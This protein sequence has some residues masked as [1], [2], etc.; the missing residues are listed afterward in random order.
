MAAKLD[1]YTNA[2]GWRVHG[3]IG[4]GLAHYYRPTL[5]G[6]LTGCGCTAI[7]WTERSLLFPERMGR[8]KCRRCIRATAARGIA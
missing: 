3:K 7:H 2:L 8:G 5:I 1:P 4:S 6:L